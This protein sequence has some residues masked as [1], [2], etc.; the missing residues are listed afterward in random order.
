MV[1]MAKQWDVEQGTAKPAHY[2]VLKN[3]IGFGHEQFEKLVLLVKW[4]YR[5]SKSF[6]IPS[7]EAQS[8]A[9]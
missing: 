3:E 5:T 1:E 7:T 9:R 8:W 2:V 6:N 4:G